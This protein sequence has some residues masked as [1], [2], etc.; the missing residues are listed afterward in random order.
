MGRWMLSTLGGCLSLGVLMVVVGVFVVQALFDLTFGWISY[1]IRLVSTGGINWAPVTLFGGLL[2]ALAFAAHL[3]L[4]GVAARMSPPRRWR[5]RD[6][7]AAVGLILALL[8]AGMA[9]AGIG[10]QVGWLTRAEQP[11][12]R[13]SWDTV[14]VKGRHI[15][16]NLRSR[17]RSDPRHKAFPLSELVVGHE[18]FHMVA[19]G[20]TGDSAEAVLIFSRDR[21]ELARQGGLL[22]HAVKEEERLGPDAVA[23]RLA[24][25]RQPPAR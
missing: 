24:E 4:T 19:L 20:L 2:A 13:S 25:L 17:S 6:T 5:R 9:M 8:I 16:G 1:T 21:E 10:H 3:L 14:D 15:C 7:L 23:T 12:I 11:L 22:C 18:L